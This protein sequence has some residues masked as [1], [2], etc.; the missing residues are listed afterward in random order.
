MF[1]NY[2]FLNRLIVEA[3]TSLKGSIIT[4]IFSQEKDK[5]IIEARNNNSY[6]YLEISV[7][8][9]FP[10]LTIKDTFNRAKKNTVN[11]FNEILPADFL[12][13]EIAESDRIIK[14]CLPKGGIYFTIRGKYTNIFLLDEDGYISFFKNMPVEFSKDSIKD[15]IK[16]TKFI[17][18][19]NY[20]HPFSFPNKI[21]LDAL[22]L[23]Y[24]FLGKEILIEAK[25]R[26]NNVNEESIVLIKKILKEIETGKPLVISDWKHNLPVLTFNSFISTSGENKEDFDDTVSAL[27]Y[28]ISQKYYFE[29]IFD[30]RKRIYKYLVNELGRLSNKLNNLK[31]VMAKGSREVDY[32]RLGNLL[33]INIKGIKPGM[34]EIELQDIY[35]DNYPVKIKLDPS[36]SPQKNADKY[37]EKSKDNKIKFEKTKELFNNAEEQYKKLKSI[38]KEFLSVEKPEEYQNIMK[39]LKL[40]EH[41]T[42]KKSE[43]ILAKFKHYL[44][45][46]KYNVFVGKDSQNNDLLTTKFAKQNDYWFHARSVPGSHVVLRVENTKEAIPKSILKKTAALTAYHSKAKTSSLAPVSYALKKYVVKKKGM[47]PGKV[48]ML[49]EDV[50]LVKPEIPNGCEYLTSE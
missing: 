41:V 15:E 6:K 10:Y 31:A 33:L 49:K 29:D 32:Q 36:L 9:G 25:T 38:E 45:E 18:T 3:N 35:S 7:N 34:N 17:S 39:E 1:K 40:K 12:L 28:Y 8:P 21:D 44:I 23:N 2:F 48:A 22:Q 11:V 46:G 30:K 26:Q 27:N 19:F 13:F 24:P 14:I 42:E 37:F 47:E 4:S 50:L 20:L 43:D 16:R 5:I